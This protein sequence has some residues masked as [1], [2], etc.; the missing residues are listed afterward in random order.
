MGPRFRGGDDA[1]DF[2]DSFGK[3]FFS[4]FSLAL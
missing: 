1:C 4:V 3:P 2:H